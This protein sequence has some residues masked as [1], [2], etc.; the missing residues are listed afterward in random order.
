MN[1]EATTHFGAIIDQ[2]TWGHRFLNATFGPEALPTVGWQ[3]DPYGH[4]LSYTALTAAMGFDAMVGQ[5]IDYQEW[6]NRAAT[7]SLEFQWKLPQL[8]SD[9]S[10]SVLGHIL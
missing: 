4:S 1:D 3:I 5:K 9:P 10:P 8:G 6:R 7:K 2:M